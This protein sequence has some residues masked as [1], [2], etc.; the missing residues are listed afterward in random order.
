[1]YRRTNEFNSSTETRVIQNDDNA[2][3]LIAR[4]NAIA[5]P[6]AESSDSDS[7]YEGDV[8]TNGEDDEEDTEEET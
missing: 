3:E 7:D 2:Q 5:T 8:D 1:V 4:L 6:S